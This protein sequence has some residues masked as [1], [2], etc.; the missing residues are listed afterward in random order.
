[1]HDYKSLQQTN[2]ANQREDGRSSSIVSERSDEPI[3]WSPSPSCHRG[4]GFP[5]DSSNPEPNHQR[6]HTPPVARTASRNGSS[7]AISQ[8]GNSTSDASTDM[9]L[10]ESVPLVVGEDA[11]T[12][13]VY[14]SDANRRKYPS[15]QDSP[16]SLR[17]QRIR[18]QSQVGK[19]LPGAREHVAENSSQN[20]DTIISQTHT[21]PTSQGLET[22]KL[23]Q[24][25]EISVAQRSGLG[26]R[27]NVCVGSPMSRNFRIDT[28]SQQS[29][30]SPRS[31]KPEQ[32]A[33][34]VEVERY[35][36]ANSGNYK[37]LD[38][39]YTSQDQ[40]GENPVVTAR[41]QRREFLQ[42][43]NDAQDET[44]GSPHTLVVSLR[45]PKKEVAPHDSE[46]LSSSSQAKPRS[47]K[48]KSGR[49][50]GNVSPPPTRWSIAPS[51]VS[52]SAVNLTSHEQE[53][54]YVS[55]ERMTAIGEGP[56]L[57]RRRT[58]LTTN[59]AHEPR[60][61]TSAEPVLSQEPPEPSRGIFIKFIQ[62]YPDYSAGQSHL[63]NLC[64]DIDNLGKNLHKSLWDD[65][66]VCSATRFGEKSGQ[67]YKDFYDEH[68][69]EPTHT[70]RIINPST[71][72]V[73]LQ[74]S[75]T[76]SMSNKSHASTLATPD[77]SRRSSVQVHVK[78]PSG[79]RRVSSYQSPKLNQASTSSPAHPP[80]QKRRSLPWQGKRSFPTGS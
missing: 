28:Y 46:K 80:S 7:P 23:L 60:V 69:E 50:D 21:S 47:G 57:K 40:V 30:L 2:P 66:I 5:V 8:S 64:E 67:P 36:L 73:I 72:A 35:S 65:Y 31:P 43:I 19:N 26:R 56:P 4:D 71:L 45:S 75:Q 58:E 11:Y 53:K 15:E 17:S 38:L 74:S 62:S 14:D 18:Q 55:N 20:D 48:P 51:L 3:A 44:S 61:V 29:T 22:A 9:G 49:I 1:M 10:E 77:S 68:V 54:R 78:N 39:A 32:D 52:D 16:M 37:N 27:L 25:S 12:N 24:D 79:T 76:V 13:D 41:R 42:G 33:Q 70:K 34:A 63:R 59:D 6:V